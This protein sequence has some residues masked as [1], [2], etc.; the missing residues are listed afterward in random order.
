[1]LSSLTLFPK[2]THAS[3]VAVYRPTL[4]I[5][6]TV[7]A[8]MTAFEAAKTILEPRLTLTESHL[9]TIIFTTLI[10]LVIGLS[11]IRNAAQL[12]QQL[13]KELN[14][15][16]R[17]EKALRASEEQVRLLL[18]S[19]AEAIYGIDLEGNC[20]LCNTACARIL[21]YDDPAELLGK[22]MHKIMHHS[23]PDGMPYQEK[24]CRIYVAFQ[25]GQG[26]HVD[27]EVLWRRDGS[28]FPAEYWSYPMRQNGR[29]IGSV[30]T[31]LDITKRRRTEEALRG[32]EQRFRTAFQHAPNGM[33]LTGF[34]AIVG[35]GRSAHHV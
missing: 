4:A 6:G 3:A 23:R 1:M 20:T 34:D 22:H 16:K 14:E 33:C 29:I 7:V 18:D 13:L 32:S 26:T 21:G 25:N 8:V 5:G 10:A 9:Q 30:V 35:H 2:K 19:T 12:N 15:R 24:E 17:A 31:F 27:D 28:S 11:G